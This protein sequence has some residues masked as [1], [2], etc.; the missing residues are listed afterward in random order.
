[1]PDSPA[2]REA[3]D[4]PKVSIVSLMVFRELDPAAMRALMDSPTGEYKTGVMLVGR[5]ALPTG[6]VVLVDKT[7]RVERF[8]DN[9]GTD[10]G[11][12]LV[13]A[14][15]PGDET[16]QC[17]LASDHKRCTFWIGSATLPAVG[18]EK[19]LLEG[20]L[21]LQMGVGERAAESQKLP[22]KL[23]QEYEAGDLKLKVIAMSVE[24]TQGTLSVTFSSPQS[25]GQIKAIECTDEAGKTVAVQLQD[26]YGQREQKALAIELARPV[27]EMTL[28]VVRYEKIESVKVP[29]NLEV[30]VGL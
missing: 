20:S 26:R 24:G 6:N 8:A 22:L 15:Y 29:V 10:F 30:K 11:N 1:M 7:L 12:G 3:D 2:T 5:V 4:K 18:A 25:P 23:G 16:G 21:N 28:R 9:K 27:K 19:L 17:Y 13:K 14:R